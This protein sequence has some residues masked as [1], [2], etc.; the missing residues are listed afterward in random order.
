MALRRLVV[1]MA[2]VMLASVALTGAAQGYSG[3]WGPGQ[4]P[5]TIASPGVTVAAAPPRFGGQHPDELEIAFAPSVWCPSGNKIVP[6]TVTVS[7]PSGTR[8]L[9]L[10]PSFPTEPQCKTGDDGWEWKDAAPAFIPGNNIFLYGQSVMW[11]ETKPGVN[12]RV[13]FKELT[14]ASGEDPFFYEVATASGLIAQGAMTAT[15]FAVGT[16]SGTTKSSNISACEREGRDI[17]SGPSGEL[18]CWVPYAEPEY[19]YVF[20]VNG[21]PP[22]PAPPVAP[23]A[24]LP[25]P[26]API[27]HNPP[28]TLAR[29]GQFAKFAAELRFERLLPLKHFHATYCRPW[30]V[31][32]RYR[33]NVVWRHGVYSFAG[34][35]EVGWT[36]HYRYGLHVVRT[37]RSTHT[38][39]TFRVP[40]GVIF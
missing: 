22:P 24:P 40:Y 6:I 19:E 20:S 33:C 17:H 35:V 23:A 14:T 15:V 4:E 1:A 8:S 10:T 3:P 32:G 31:P 29:A 28:I 12:P 16:A 27:K 7:D 38:R 34:T 18:Y 2:F 5:A 25:P 21:W 9:T 37:D 39:R 13:T 26:A 11:M 30:K 36:P